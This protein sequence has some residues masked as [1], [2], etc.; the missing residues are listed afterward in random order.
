[1][2][3]SIPKA[4]TSLRGI[5]AAQHAKKQKHDSR[6]Q[7]RPH[8]E[9]IGRGRSPIG[10]RSQKAS[11]SQSSAVTW[12]TGFLDHDVVPA[13]PDGATL[14]SEDHTFDDWIQFDDGDEPGLAVPFV[15]QSP[16][17]IDVNDDLKAYKAAIFDLFDIRC[18]RVTSNIWTLEGWNKGEPEVGCFY[19]VSIIQLPERFLLSCDCAR[20]RSGSDCI[21]TKL[22]S[23][24]WTLFDAMQCLDPAGSPTVVEIAVALYG[25]PHWLS[26]LAQNEHQTSAAPGLH[27]RCIVSSCGLDEWECNAPSCPRG[28]KP[29]SECIHRGRA[30]AYVIGL[31]GDSMLSSYHELSAEDLTELQ[32]CPRIVLQRRAVSHLPI[33]PPRFALLPDEHAGPPA[34]SVTSLPPV[35]RLDDHSR[36]Y[37]Q[38]WRSEGASVGNVCEEERGVPLARTFDH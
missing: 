22:C 17:I 3:P 30:K 31:H 8:A 33:S 25:R 2:I 6:P 27:K 7:K 9:M 23:E 35:L 38:Q 24:N 16:E 12:E 1:M 20:S 29:A 14:E 5:L 18:E 37:A 15:P 19:H 4:S 32:R 34:V 28:R 36:C 13:Q 21:H 11:S 10:S 26:V